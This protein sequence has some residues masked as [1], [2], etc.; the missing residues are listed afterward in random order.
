MAEILFISKSKINDY[1][2]GATWFG[3]EALI[4]RAPTMFWGQSYSW[5]I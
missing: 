1:E 2:F 3:A 4:K 5:G